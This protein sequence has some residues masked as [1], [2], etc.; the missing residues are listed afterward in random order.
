MAKKN[1]NI[2]QGQVQKTTMAKTNRKIYH[3]SDSVAF[4]RQII[5]DNNTGFTHQIYA[6]WL[7]EQKLPNVARFV[8]NTSYTRCYTVLNFCDNPK[9]F[10][11]RYACPRLCIF[12]SL[13]NLCFVHDRWFI[14]FNLEVTITPGLAVHVTK[15]LAEEGVELVSVSSLF[16]SHNLNPWDHYFRIREEIEQQIES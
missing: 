16:G 10:T 13:F 5:E 3:S 9:V 2:H 4:L 15:T 8:R 11:Y 7:D 6:D 14:H 12:G 1:R